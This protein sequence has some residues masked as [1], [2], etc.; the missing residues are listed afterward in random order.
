MSLGIPKNIPAKLRKALAEELQR[1]GA[2]YPQIAGS[3]D[4]PLSPD[5]VLKM[6]RGWNSLTQSQKA[7]WNDRAR[8]ENIHEGNPSWDN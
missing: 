3:V 8:E 2:T 7:A 4:P 5:M 1:M 6:A